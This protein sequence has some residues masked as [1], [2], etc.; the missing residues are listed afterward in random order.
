MTGDE[1]PRVWVGYEEHCPHWWWNA[2]EWEL[3]DPCCVT[4]VGLVTG[5]IF[6]PGKHPK[7]TIKL[8]DMATI[9]TCE[10]IDW[11]D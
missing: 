2:G 6:V 3:S 5:D 8:M 11:N 9:E 4:E 7:P 10:E 1:I